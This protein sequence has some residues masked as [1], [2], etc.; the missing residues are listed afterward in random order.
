MLR[1]VAAGPCWRCRRNL[2][3]PNLADMVAALDRARSICERHIPRNRRGVASRQPAEALGAL[4]LAYHRGGC[5]RAPD[6][7]RYRCLARLSGIA[8]PRRGGALCRCAVSCPHRQG[9]RCRQLFAALAQGGGGYGVL[10]AFERAELMARTGDR[11]GAVDTYEKIAASAE[12]D[13][14]LRDLATLLAVMH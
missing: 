13:P 2:R 5:V 8:A 7:R 9:G 10:A 3:H 11:K 4:S 6:C 1:P 14:E 12:L